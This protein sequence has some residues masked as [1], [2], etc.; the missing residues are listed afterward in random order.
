MGLDLMKPRL[1]AESVPLGLGHQVNANR[2][3]VEG[4]GMGQ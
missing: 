2:C 3:T 4:V 1:T